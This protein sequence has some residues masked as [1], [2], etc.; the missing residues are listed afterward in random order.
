MSKTLFEA[1][2]KGAKYE[3]TAVK[4]G[5]YNHVFTHP[6]MTMEEAAELLGARHI[7]LTTTCL[8]CQAE[9]HGEWY[10][11]PPYTLVCGACGQ[12]HTVEYSNEVK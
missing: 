2:F 11:E 8:T 12:S 7:S 10:G 4:P 3:S 6:E 1:L 9:V 5:V